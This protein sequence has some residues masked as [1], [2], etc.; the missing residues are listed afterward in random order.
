MNTKKGRQKKVTR[1]AV[2]AGT[3]PVS[4]QLTIDTKKGYSTRDIGIDSTGKSIPDKSM[5]TT[6]YST[7]DTGMDTKGWAHTKTAIGVGETE[8]STDY[9]GLRQDGK[10]YKAGNQRLTPAV[11]VIQRLM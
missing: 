9:T 5:D 7:P 8:C 10:G 3:K 1:H 2:L 11:G 6:G 4:K